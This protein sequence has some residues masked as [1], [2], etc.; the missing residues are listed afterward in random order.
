MVLSVRVLPDDRD[1]LGRSDV[2]AGRDGGRLCESEDFDEEFGGM[3]NVNLPHIAWSSVLLHRK[4]F[5]V[6]DQATYI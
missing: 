6:M 4:A 1:L 2:V 3:S 5:V